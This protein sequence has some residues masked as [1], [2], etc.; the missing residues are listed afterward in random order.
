MQEAMNEMERCF[1]ECKVNDSFGTILTGISLENSKEHIGRL[2][3]IEFK[4]ACLGR[5]RAV[6]QQTLAY[7]RRCIKRMNEESS[8]LEKR[9]EEHENAK[10]PME[11]SP[12]V[13][14]VGL[15]D[16]FLSGRQPQD[17]VKLLM[18]GVDDPLA[19]EELKAELMRRKE[20]SCHELMRITSTPG[21]NN[22]VVKDTKNQTH[23]L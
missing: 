20:T 14:G 22:I 23:T 6:L 18:N 21:S 8:E 13:T 1:R 10:L 4:Y 3:S 5:E 11:I 2:Q 16:F 15:T 17:V 7:K 19:F 9:I 12:S